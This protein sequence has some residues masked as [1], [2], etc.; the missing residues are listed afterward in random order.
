MRALLASAA[1]AFSLAAPVQAQ[2]PTF[3]KVDII[4]KSLI[5]KDMP[6]GPTE[7][8]IRVPVSLAKGFLDMAGS[9]DVKI[10]HKTCHNVNVDQLA[11]MLASAKAGDLLLEL[12]TDKGDLVKITLQ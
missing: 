6:D 5:N 7:V 8:H 11:K 12:T 2:A 9:K 4:S 1:L 3:L 10:N